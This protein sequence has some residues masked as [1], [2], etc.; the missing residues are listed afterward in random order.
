MRSLSLNP[1]RI[2]KDTLEAIFISVHTPVPAPG[3]FLKK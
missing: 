2:Y 3:E 1:E